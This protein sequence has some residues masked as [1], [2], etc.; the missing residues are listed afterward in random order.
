MVARFFFCAPGRRF[1]I[2]YFEWERVPEIRNTSNRICPVDLAGH[3]GMPY[4][5]SPRRTAPRTA[6]EDPYEA[7]ERINTELF[8][9][10]CDLLDD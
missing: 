3:F 8:E 1:L 6:P 5:L 7:R 9:F 2:N 4:V 10:N